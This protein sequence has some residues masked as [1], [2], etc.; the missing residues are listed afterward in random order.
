MSAV[1]FTIRPSKTY[2]PRAPS[3]TFTR[4]GYQRT[5]S[6]PRGEHRGV[7]MPAPKD[8]I[9][10]LPEKAKLIDKG[11]DDAAGHYMEWMFLTGPWKGR[12]GRWF[13]MHRAC[14]FSVGTVRTRKYAIGRVGTTGNSTGPHVHFELGKTRWDKGR[15]PRWDPTQAMRDAVAGKDY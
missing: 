15:D 3:D 12:Y 1:S 10:Q 5:P 7:D 8:E 6:N 4:T 2:K 14:G 9:I 13:H 11:W